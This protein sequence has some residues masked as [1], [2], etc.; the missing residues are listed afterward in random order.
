MGREIMLEIELSENIEMRRVVCTSWRK[1]M[2]I[3]PQTFTANAVPSDR[4]DAALCADALEAWSWC[5]AGSERP[6]T[7]GETMAN[8][9]LRL[10]VDGSLES[11]RDAGKRFIGD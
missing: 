4:S 2:T 7:F 9:A 5:M 1:G 6:K 3:W 8:I 11:F 10:G